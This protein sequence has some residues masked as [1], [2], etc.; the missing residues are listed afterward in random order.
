MC[1]RCTN[2]FGEKKFP[3]ATIGR[4]VE[5]NLQENRGG[6]RIIP[7]KKFYGG[8]SDVN[9]LRL[10]ASGYIFPKRTSNFSYL[11]LIYFNSSR[12][13]QSGDLISKCRAVAGVD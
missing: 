2:H 3:C 4:R 1:G 6:N 8:I 11:P 10:N 5:F 9:I 13:T 7:T 12:F